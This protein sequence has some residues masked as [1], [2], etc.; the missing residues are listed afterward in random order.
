MT[1]NIIDSQAA[2]A[3]WIAKAH[4]M[5]TVCLELETALSIAMASYPTADQA[6]RLMAAD[7][8][9]GEA[10]AALGEAEAQIRGLK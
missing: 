6:Q 10:V 8:Q 7:A 1:N 9:L 5:I 2:R 4:A 3:A